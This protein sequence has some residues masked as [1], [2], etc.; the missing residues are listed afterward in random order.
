MVM[1]VRLFGI[2]ITVMGVMF[3][4][5]PNSLKQYF[6]F[7]KKENRLQIGGIIALVFGIICLIAASQCRVVWLIIF[8]GVWSIVKGVVLF[9]IDKKKFFDYIDWWLEKPVS[10]LRYIG[11][12]AVV[13]GVLVVFSA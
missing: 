8:L 10:V 3:L 2:A 12:I 13:F 6:L 11:I 9:A 7:W 5:N 4:V 1:L